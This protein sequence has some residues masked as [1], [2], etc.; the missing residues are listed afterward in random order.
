[1][2]A[3]SI[4]LALTSIFLFVVN[5]ALDAER[6]ELKSKLEDIEAKQKRRLRH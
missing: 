5:L 1:M 6:K 2:I 4:V 3:I